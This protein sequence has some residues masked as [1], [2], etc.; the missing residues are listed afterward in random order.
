M[1]AKPRTSRAVSVEPR[2]PATVEKRTNTGVRLPAS[3][4]S[5][6]RV[7]LRQRLVALEVAVRAGAARVDDA[8]GD[9]L[10]VEV[11]DLLAEDEVLEQRR[12][13]AGRP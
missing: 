12:A 2:S 10:V 3:A 5:D 8:L 13:R 1:T 9:A 4:N 7:S 11:G 6:A